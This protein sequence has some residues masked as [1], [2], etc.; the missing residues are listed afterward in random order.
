MKKVF[1]VTGIVC[2]SFVVS[3]QNKSNLAGEYTVKENCWLS[4]FFT[5]TSEYTRNYKIDVNP[6]DNELLSITIGWADYTG[7]SLGNNYFTIIDTNAY[8]FGVVVRDSFYLYY[9]KTYLGEESVYAECI[10]VGSRKTN[11]DSSQANVKKTSAPSQNRISKSHYSDP[12]LLAQAKPNFAGEYK[13]TTFSKELIGNKKASECESSITISYDAD[14]K[15][16]LS[17]IVGQHEMKPLDDNYFFVSQ[18]YPNSADMSVYGFGLL[19]NDSIYLYYYENGKTDTTNSICVGTRKNSTVTG[20][21]SMPATANAFLFQNTPNPF[22]TQTEIKY[23]VPENAN[24]AVIYVFSLNGN[25]LLTKPISQLGNGGVTINGNE[26]EAGM[27]IYTL[28]VD[29]QEV[30]SKR[31]ILN[32]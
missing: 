28:A 24:N 19:K 18:H 15:P 2:C 27:Y 5:T 25:L 14:D 32:K 12:E 17:G 4:S 20:F 21:N 31:M 23:F 22:S 8:S 13:I 10:C 1:L 7:K 26:L 3:A 6:D 11:A 29:G 9:N 30:D 16:I